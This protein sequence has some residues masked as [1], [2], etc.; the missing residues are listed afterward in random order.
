MPPMQHPLPPYPQWALAVNHA[1]RALGSLYERIYASIRARGHPPEDESV[2][3]A[4]LARIKDPK[5]GGCG[6]G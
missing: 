5:T 3:W 6:R 4:C 2:L 1:Q